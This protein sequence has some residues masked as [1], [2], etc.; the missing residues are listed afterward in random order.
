MSGFSRKAAAGALNFLWG[1]EESLAKP[2]NVYLALLTAVPTN[3]STGATITE[4]TGATGYLRKEVA[5]ANIHTAEEGATTII[6]TTAE[7]IFAAITAGSGVITAWALC[8]SSETGKGN[9]IM[10]GTATSTEISK[11]QTPPTIATGSPEGT[12]V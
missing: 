12:L 7:T 2:A 10:W 5:V 11:T 8:D 6:K 9:V 4:A 1:K 3:A